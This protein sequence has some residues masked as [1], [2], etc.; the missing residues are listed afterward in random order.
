MAALREA[1][2]LDHEGGNFRQAARHFQEV[3]ELYENELDDPK[4]AYDAYEKAADLFS[5]DDSPAY[6]SLLL[7]ALALH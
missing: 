7:A 5:A 4:G 6:S 3:A 1:I 2:A